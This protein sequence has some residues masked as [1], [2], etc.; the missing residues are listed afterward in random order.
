MAWRHTA[1]S[2]LKNFRG[3]IGENVITLI[4]IERWDSEHFKDE[5]EA[6]LHRKV[7]PGKA[8]RPRKKT[9][10]CKANQLEISV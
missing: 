7:R 2:G 10:E 6:A 4:S 1:K 8:G 9:E 5:I 3:K